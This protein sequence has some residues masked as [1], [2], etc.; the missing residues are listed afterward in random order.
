MQWGN[1]QAQAL[2]AVAA[3]LKSDQQV[4]RLFGYAGTGKTTLAKHLTESVQGRVIFGAYTGKAAHVLASKGCL[5][6]QTLHSLIYRPKDKGKQKLRELEEALMANVRELTEA[7]ATEQQISADRRVRDLRA[8]VEAERHSAARPL[9]SLNDESELRSA[10][11]LV[12]DEVSQVGMQMGSDLVSFGKKILVL[13]DPYQLPPVGEG[14][15]FTEGAKPEVLLTE[16]H[17]QARDNPIIRL[18]TMVREERMPPLGEYGNSRVVRKEDICPEDAMRADQILVGKNAT[19][20]ATNR[21][22][23]NLRGATDFLPEAGDKVVCL[24]N[25]SERGLLNGALFRVKESFGQPDTDRVILGIH[26]EENEQRYQEVEMHTHHFENRGKELAWF[27][28]NEA[29]EF[30]YGYAL[31]VHKAQGSQWNNVMMFDEG[32]SFR[33]ASWRWRYT[34]VTRAAEEVTW[35]KMP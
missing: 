35:V 23:R 10:K 5:G 19:R 11:L 15:Y 30:D 34:A 20:A 17:R 24:R 33:D 28:K 1:Q 8:L 13:G 3:W 27:E 2:D 31:T 4:F 18:A 7:G 21:R 9:F 26:P 22:V 32:A 25:D 14:G 16:I 29:A 12:V 6:A